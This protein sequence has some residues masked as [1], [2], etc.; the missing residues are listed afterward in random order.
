MPNS[1]S[2]KKALRQS[3]KRRLRN[4]QQRSR[5]RTE[6]KKFRALMAE[7]PSRADADQAFSRVAKI[8]DQAA[9]RRLIHRNTA[10]RKKSRLAA[11]KKSACS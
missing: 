7:S 8:I 3:L 11:L 6:V 9:A 1:S 4:R 10:S 2:A 5:L